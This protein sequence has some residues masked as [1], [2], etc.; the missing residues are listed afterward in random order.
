MLCGDLEVIPWNGLLIFA[1]MN[2]IFSARYLKRGDLPS[3][4]QMSLEE[5]IRMRMHAFNTF[6]WLFVFWGTL[7]RLLYKWVT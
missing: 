7:P 4:T 3:L 6:F 1:L 5:F 2:V